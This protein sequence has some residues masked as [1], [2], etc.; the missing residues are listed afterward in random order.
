MG[1]DRPWWCALVGA[2]WGRPRA[3]PGGP[4]VGAG[5]TLSESVTPD[6]LP[7]RFGF[8]AH[9]QRPSPA[10]ARP[11]ESPGVGR[12]MPRPPPPTRD[13]WGLRGPVSVSNSWQNGW[14]ACHLRRKH[15]GT[16]GLQSVSPAFHAG[17]CA[18]ESRHPLS[19]PPGSRP[20][21]QLNQCLDRPQS[22]MK[23]AGTL[24]LRGESLVALRI[25]GC[26]VH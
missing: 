4:T 26:T 15:L 21:P 12:A 23:R 6:G 22:P 8:I 7:S 10:P 20:P 16:Q 17:C 18:F 3:C 14:G 2:A 1:S 9:P 25:R 5:S 24:P 13:R 19:R 11:P